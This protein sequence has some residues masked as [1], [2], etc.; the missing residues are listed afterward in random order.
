MPTSIQISAH[1]SNDTKARLDRFVRST[2][3][4]RARV[5][6][7]ALLHHLQVLDELPVDAV[8]PPRMVLAAESAEQVRDLLTRPPRPTAAMKRL[9]D[10]R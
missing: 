8:V 1:V 6:E 10:D 7:D 9:F 4:T 2:G 5:I 3:L